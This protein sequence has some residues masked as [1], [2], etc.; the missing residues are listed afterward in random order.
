MISLH[1]LSVGFI[2]SVIAS[3]APL[4]KFQTLTIDVYRKK[5][6]AQSISKVLLGGVILCKLIEFGKHY[7]EN[8]LCGS[9]SQATQRHASFERC[10]FKESK[11]NETFRITKS[12]EVE[13]EV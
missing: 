11:I 6:P 10:I 4:G 13:K 9:C 3:I 2:S 8:S 5:S 12:V 1:C 7:N